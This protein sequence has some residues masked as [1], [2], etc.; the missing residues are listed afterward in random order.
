M[1]SRTRKAFGTFEKRAPRL[2]SGGVPGT[3]NKSVPLG[4]PKIVLTVLISRKQATA[5]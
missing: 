5:E 3:S 1:A 2:L 4:K